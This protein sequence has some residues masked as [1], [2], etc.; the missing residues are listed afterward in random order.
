MKNIPQPKLPYQPNKSLGQNFI[1]DK[2]YLHKIVSSFLVDDKTIIIEIGSGYGSLTNLLVETPCQKIISLEKDKNLFQWLEKNNK[3]D[4]ITYL[5]QDALLVDWKNFCLEYWDNSIM[6]I[7]NLPYY[8]TNSLIINLLLSYQNFKSL[9]FLIQKEVAQKW[10]ASINKYNSKYSALSVFIN[11]LTDTKLVFE[12]TR[13]IFTPI[14][15]VDGSLLIINPQENNNI[16]KEQLPYFL[17]F[18]KNCFR[19]RRKTLWNNLLNFA[20]KHEKDWEKYFNEKGYSSTI[21]PQNITPVEY[22]EL[23][24]YW[25]KLKK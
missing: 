3:H 20:N 5:C 7:G 11:Y 2:N 16:S 9:V 19:F 23:F 13:E 12:I 6:V 17:R 18:L 4:K 1:F 25:Q 22:A 8:I 21:R 10:V 14:P 15:E 24:F